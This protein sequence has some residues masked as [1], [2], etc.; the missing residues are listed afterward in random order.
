MRRATA[1]T[2]LVALLLTAGSA[3]GYTLAERLY[4]N[5]ITPADGRSLAM[6]EAGLASADGV[7]GMAMNP[8]LIA[9]TDG[10]QVGFSS[11]LINA[12]EARNVPVHDSFDGVIV[13]NTYALNSALYDRYIGAVAYRSPNAGRWMPVVGLTYR[14]RLDMSYDYHVQ[15]R[16]P[17]SQ[18]EPEDRIIEDYFL[19]SDGGVDAL[20]VTL[21]QTIVEDVHVGL[22]IDFLRGGFDVRERWVHP[23]DSEIDDAES[24]SQFDDMSGSQVSLGFLY[25]RFHRLDIACVYRSGYTLDGDYEIRSA[26]GDTSEGG[27]E[28][29]YPGTFV[30][31]LEYHPRNEILT[32]VS[33]DVE[34]AQ[35]SEFEDDLHGDPDF[36]NTITYRLGVEHG[37]YDNSFARFGFLYQP[38]YIDDGVTRTGFS[39]GL[40]LDVLG[41][42]VDMGGQIGVREYDIEDVRYDF[43]NEEF[44]TVEARVRETTSRATVSVVHTF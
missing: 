21:G 4:G 10:L 8:A 25:E 30:V 18:A 43:V 23:E 35:W 33:L 9:K 12:E 19:E 6:G 42:R 5:E 31:G 3:W 27:F 22:G 16:D 24:W 7:R 14:P 2:A 1:V 11:L 32:A 15:Y 13:D 28:Y 37:F 29:E 34:F 38:A 26:F 41:V 20:T 39:A 40:G 17:D 44:V 36:E